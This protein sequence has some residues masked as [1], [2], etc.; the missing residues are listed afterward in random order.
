[1]VP[2]QYLRTSFAFSQSG[3]LALGLKPNFA[4]W[5]QLRIFRYWI[6]SQ[7][8]QSE[9]VR[10]ASQGAPGLVRMTPSEVEQKLR[11]PVFAL[12]GT[13]RRTYSWQRRCVQ[14]PDSLKRNPLLMHQP[15]WEQASLVSESS[16]RS[17]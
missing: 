5:F 3:A 12:T 15:S 4:A 14:A 1:M 2:R 9:A 8:L 10:G 7:L 17:A 6:G 11:V 16:K 13:A